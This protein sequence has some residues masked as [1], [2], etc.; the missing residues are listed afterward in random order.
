MCTKSQNHSNDC[1]AESHS[2]TTTTTGVAYKDLSL[3]NNFIE[4]L[5][6][7]GVVQSAHVVTKQARQQE[8]QVHGPHHVARQC[9]QQLQYDSS[10]ETTTHVQGD[11]WM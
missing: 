8:E 6:A 9:V 11:L 4:E 10:A 5:F 1:E 7:A 3:A 2:T